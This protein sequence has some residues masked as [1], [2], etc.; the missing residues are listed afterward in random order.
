MKLRRQVAN[1]GEPVENKAQVNQT[2]LPVGVGCFI[3]LRSVLS[4]QSWNS[5][6]SHKAKR[7]LLLARLIEKQLK[8]LELDEQ[9]KVLEAKS[10]TDLVELKLALA[11]EEE[12]APLKYLSRYLRDCHIQ[13]EPTF[14]APVHS[15]IEGAIN[16]RVDLPK[17]GLEFFTGNLSSYWRSVRQFE[18]YAENGIKYD[19]QRV[20]Y[21]LHYCQ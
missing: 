1:A 12:N 3:P 21:L 15:T 13:T 19:G 11:E 18:Y 2:V 14:E 9:R 4:S 20:L 7:E 8:K 5:S 17:F 6:V 10:E 16:Y